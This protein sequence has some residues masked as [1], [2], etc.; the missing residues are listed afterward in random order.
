MDR[1]GRYKRSKPDIWQLP[2]AN[3]EASAKAAAKPLN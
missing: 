2:A 3:C 1:D